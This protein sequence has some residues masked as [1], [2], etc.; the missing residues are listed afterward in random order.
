MKLFNNM[1]SLVAI[2]IL[3]CMSLFSILAVCEHEPLIIRALPDQ[4]GQAPLGWAFDEEGRLF[5][6]APGFDNIKGVVV[7]AR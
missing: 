5:Y 3:L 7:N 4:P 6:V 2:A 1:W